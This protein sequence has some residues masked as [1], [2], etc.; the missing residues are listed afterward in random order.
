MSLRMSLKN[1][2]RRDPVAGLRE[3]AAELR[4]SLSRRAVVAGSPA[5]KLS[6]STAATGMVKLKQAKFYCR[7]AGLKEILIRLYCLK[8]DIAMLSPP[9]A[10][11]CAI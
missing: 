3:R 10:R 6:G 11:P 9:M 1:L 4:G 8:M 2:I 7:S 5:R